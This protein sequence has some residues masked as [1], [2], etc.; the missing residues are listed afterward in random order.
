MTHLLEVEGLRKQFGATTALRDVSLHLDDGEVLALLGDNGAGKSTLIKAI[1]GVHQ[2]DQGQ[3]L[4]DGKALDVK[5][6]S[7]ARELGIETLHQDLSLFDNLAATANFFIGRERKRGGLLGALGWLDEKAMREEWIDHL[8]RMQV[9]MPVASGD[10]GVLSG[11]QRQAVAVLR[12]VAFATRLVILDEPT[13]ALGL[14]ESRQVLELVQRL[15]EHGIA[16]ILISHNLDHVM[17]VADR[18]V[19]LRQGRYVGEAP[20]TPEHHE[21]L[22]SLIVGASVGGAGAAN[23]QGD[24]DASPEGARG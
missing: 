1:S 4:L 20:P 2:L 15:P 24:R 8:E 18:A 14:R 21:R 16:V 11:G 9:R 22:V 12:A 3:I 23:H 7:D 6:P 17:Q 5:E 13:A 10:V 19:V